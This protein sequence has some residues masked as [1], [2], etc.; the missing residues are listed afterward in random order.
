MKAIPMS[1]ILHRQWAPFVDLEVRAAADGEGRTV[2]GLA[3]PFDTPTPIREGGHSFDEV[4][5]MGAFAETINERGNR[6][7]F[8]VNHDRRR[9]PLGKAVSLREDVAGLVGEFYIPDTAEGNNALKLIE[10]GVLDAMS[11][12]FVP[13]PN[14]TR[15]VP[16]RDDVIERLAVKLL[17]VSAVAFPAYESALITG[18]R[19]E[20]LDPDQVEAA[21]D[22]GDAPDQRIQRARLLAL[23]D[24]QI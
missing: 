13:T 23:L 11:V 17:E 19:S 16:G 9:L 4:F 7:K 1:D 12:G 3:V 5:R 8:L 18:V 14:G 21:P 20:D 15:G 6:V 24:L 22:Q 10:T 2:T